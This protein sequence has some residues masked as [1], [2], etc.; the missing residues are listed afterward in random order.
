MRVCVCVCVRERE[1]DR[2]TA[3]V[4]VCER[5][6]GRLGMFVWRSERGKSVNVCVCVCVC[7]CVFDK[8]RCCR[9]VCEKHKKS[10]R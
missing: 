9:F 5:D 6:M 4:N 3:L 8:E 10:E 7:V 2:Q 1:K